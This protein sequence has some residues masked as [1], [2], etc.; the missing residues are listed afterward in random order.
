M[1]YANSIRVDFGSPSEEADGTQLCMT[2]Y[3]YEV[4]KAIFV[5]KIHAL[6]RLSMV[7]CLYEDLQAYGSLVV[8]LLLLP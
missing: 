3:E 7:W 5:W 6:A 1:Y 4:N 8:S 2:A